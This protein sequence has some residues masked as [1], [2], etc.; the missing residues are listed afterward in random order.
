M[1]Q[2]RRIRKGDSLPSPLL[3]RCI[4]ALTAAALC[5]SVRWPW[6]R[7]R[8]VLSQMPEPGAAQD[9]SQVPREGP[10]A[11]GQR[12]QPSDRATIRG[13]QR[14]L[15]ARVGPGREGG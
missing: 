13:A 9:L 4:A 15:A 1:W 6:V 10:N 8:L 12:L 7:V 2:V 11:D 5:G 14:S 3:R